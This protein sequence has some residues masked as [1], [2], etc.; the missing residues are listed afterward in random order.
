MSFFKEISTLT[1]ANLP[2]EKLT[3]MMSTESKLLKLS[4]GLPSLTKSS[5]VSS[6]EDGEKVLDSEPEEPTLR[7]NFECLFHSS[8]RSLS[9]T[10]CMLAP[11]NQDV[12][13]TA[14]VAELPNRMS[15]QHENMKV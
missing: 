1:T 7:N 3:D 10:D 8:E 11:P 14:S 5:G 13:R 15:V 12:L 9:V 4:I 6:S 2:M